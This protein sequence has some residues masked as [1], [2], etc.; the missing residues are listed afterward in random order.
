MLL[1]HPTFLRPIALI[2]HDL[3]LATGV[4]NYG[5]AHPPLTTHLE[6]AHIIP[7][8]LGSFHGKA[9]DIYIKIWVNLRRYFPALR[10]M[11]LYLRTDQFGEE[12]SDARFSNL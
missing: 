11:S 8:I 5:C 12:R 10:N 2:H 9:V 1:P 4:Y 7:F 3:G 6:A